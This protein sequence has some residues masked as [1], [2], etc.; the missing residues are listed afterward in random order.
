M[1]IRQSFTD[2]IK[3]L[4]IRG[5][6]Q[7][8]QYEKSR[9][10]DQKP[11]KSV[12]FEIA[13]TKL[14]ESEEPTPPVTPDGSFDFDGDHSLFHAA[15]EELQSL[16]PFNL[17]GD[18]SASFLSPGCDD[19]STLH[20]PLSFSKANAVDSISQSEMEKQIFSICI[21]SILSQKAT[22]HSSKLNEM[23]SSAMPPMKLSFTY[24]LRSPTKSP[25]PSGLK[26]RPPLSST[27]PTSPSLK[28]RR[29]KLLSTASS[30]EN[31][32]RTH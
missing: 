9:T 17:E 21:P 8:I 19:T 32:S 2:M 7:Q 26:C 16:L 23:V 24:P 1:G 15:K 27:F 22:D 10:V 3:A 18:L 13:E 28:S 11:I 31:M 30:I 20:Q 29:S 4:R 14:K 12:S 6:S 25:S 5:V